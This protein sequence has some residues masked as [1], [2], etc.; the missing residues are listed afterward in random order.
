[1]FPS[2]VDRDPGGVG[3]DGQ[4]V[5]VRG[6]ARGPRPTQHRP[7][8][9]CGLGH[10]AQV[11]TGQEPPQRRH[12]GQPVRPP[13]RFGARV[14][15]QGPVGQEVTAGQADLGQRPIALPAG[16]ATGSNR[17]Q[18]TSVALGDHVQPV[19]QRPPQRDAGD[20]G[21]I[22]LRSRHHRVGT[23][24]AGRASSSSS[25]SNNR[26]VSFT[27]RVPFCSVDRDFDTHDFSLQQGHFRVKTRLSPT[28]RLEDQG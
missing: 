15:Q 14:G 25:T 12:A 6:G 1:L 10:P 24:R 5:P 7:V 8:D 11:R 18:P 20:R 3:V 19:Q 22:R 2:P 4:P 17:T 21:Q 26:P 16:V 23:L 28:N 9:R 27:T 13:Q